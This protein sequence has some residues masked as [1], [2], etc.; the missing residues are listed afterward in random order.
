M[1]N[2]IRIVRVRRGL[3]CNFELLVPLTSTDICSNESLADLAVCAMKRVV[4]TGW[5]N[6]KR[7]VLCCRY[8]RRADTSRVT[9]DAGATARR[10]TSGPGRSVGEEPGTP[11][12]LAGGTT[13][14][15]CRRT[16]RVSPTNHVG[17]TLCFPPPAAPSPRR[18]RRL[19]IRVTFAFPTIQRCEL[20]AGYLPYRP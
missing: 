3:C 11:D 10:S 6:E 2:L 14:R 12:V 9:G 19:S 8:R 4:M 1:V 17:A 20:R 16:S 18:L 7:R 13:S 5:N 15:S